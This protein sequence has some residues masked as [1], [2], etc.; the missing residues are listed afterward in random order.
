MKRKYNDPKKPHIVCIRVSD[1]EMEDIQKIIHR[2]EKTA[3]QLMREAFIMLSSQWRSAGM[4]G[5]VPQC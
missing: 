5:E 4:G 3:S 2:T 1:D